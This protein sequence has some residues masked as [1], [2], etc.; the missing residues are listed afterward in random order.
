[1]ER[2]TLS[3]QSKKAIK[4]TDNWQHKSADKPSAKITNIPQKKK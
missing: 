1:M 4:N 3:N 2:K